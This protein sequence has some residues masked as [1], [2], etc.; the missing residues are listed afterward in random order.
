M[1]SSFE[2]NLAKF[3]SKQRF[4]K[5]SISNNASNSWI[6][7]SS[8]VSLVTP[9]EGIWDSRVLWMK[10]IYPHATTIDRSHFTHQQ[11]I[12]CSFEVHFLC[13]NWVLSKISGH[14]MDLGI[15]FQSCISI[16]CPMLLF[17]HVCCPRNLTSVPFSNHKHSS[18]LVPLCGSLH[19]DHLV[20]PFLHYLFL[21][22]W[23]NRMIPCKIMK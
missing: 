11:K 6:R 1:R 3:C 7:T 12:D 4:T 10:P 19:G 8:V 2:V 16:P 22:G 18:Q 5:F 21:K 23:Q 17:C 15:L 13:N 9:E 14:M 20:C